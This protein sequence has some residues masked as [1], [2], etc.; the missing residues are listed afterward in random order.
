MHGVVAVAVIMSRGFCSGLFVPVVVDI[1]KLQIS[2]F[3]INC[4]LLNR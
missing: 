1:A 2:E 3:C 4:C